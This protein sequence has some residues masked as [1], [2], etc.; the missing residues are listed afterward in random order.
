[1]KNK[2]VYIIL[3]LIIVF[4]SCQNSIAIH[5]KDIIVCIGMHRGGTSALTRGLEVLDIHLGENL[6]P[7]VLGENDKGFYEDL[8]I[9]ELNRN[10]LKQLGSN[11]NDLKVLPNEQLISKKFDALKKSKAV[12]SKKSSRW[13]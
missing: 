11:W 5:Q 1:M 7:G 2:K 13:K 9:Y 3:C 6:M 4:F 8:D 12:N 10:V